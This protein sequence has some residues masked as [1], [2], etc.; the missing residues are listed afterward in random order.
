MAIWKAR[1][2]T[3]V[4]TYFAVVRGGA[5]R[6]GLVA[7][8]FAVTLI[9]PDDSASTTLTVTES[10]QLAGIYYIDIPSAF[11]T[12]NGVGHYGLRIGIHAAAP[13]QD[14]EELESV[15][16]NTS[17]IDF[18][19]GDVWDETTSSHLTAGTTGEDLSLIKYQGSIYIDTTNGAAGTTIGINGTPDNPVDTLADALTLATSTGFRKFVIVEGNLTLT[20]ALTEWTVELR[21]EAQLNFGSQ[22]V[23]GSTFTG[24]IVTGTMTGTAVITRSFLDSVS[25]FLGTA[26]FCGLGGTITLASGESTFD[27]CHS[28][29][30]ATGI[31]TLDFVGAGRSVNLRA[32][33]GGVQVENM[34]DVSNIGTVEFVAGRIVVDSSCTAGTL[35]IR[36]ITVVTDS[37]AGTTVDTTGV[38]NQTL[39]GGAV[40][41]ESRAAHTIVGSFGE[42]VNLTAAERVNIANT[43]LDLASSIEAGFTLR[44]TM[45][46]MAATL[47]GTVSGGPGNP[48]FRSM[49]NSADRVDSVADS[50]GNRSSVTLTP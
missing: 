23:N 30:P 31:V 45:R 40:W 36:G 41:D 48:V 7:G 43:L 26:Q 47:C 15:E 34:V 27:R 13:A 28:R 18:I 19:A 8:D 21:D 14:D 24:G 2:S 11:L 50:N 9:D 6:T 12:T 49:D 35:I 10:A 44:D 39:V 32:Y 38:V 29:E 46:L 17:D 33:S 22:S 4:R 16:V 5:L 3:G 1:T 37:S 25:G 20:A 42:G